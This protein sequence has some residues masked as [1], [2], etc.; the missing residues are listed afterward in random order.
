[1]RRFQHVLTRV[2]QQSQVEWTQLALDC[3]YYDQPHFNHDFREF[4][5]F[6]PG[7]YLIRATEHL[8]HVPLD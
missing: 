6:T 4:S 8:N 3:G 2:H 1:M 5:G 7:E